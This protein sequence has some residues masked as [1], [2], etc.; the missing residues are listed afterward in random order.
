[1]PTI[2]DLA[3]APKAARARGESLRP[4]FE[5]PGLTRHR[6]AI[7]EHA[8]G[9]QI[10][11]QKDRYKVIVGLENANPPMGYEFVKGDVE[12]YDT[13]ADPAEEHN[14]RDQE[15][16]RVGDFLRYFEPFRAMRYDD[17]TPPDSTTDAATAQALI[18]LG[19]AGQ[20]KK[21]GKQPLEPPKPADATKPKDP[22]QDG[23]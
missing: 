3:R 16:K 6:A 9:W 17:L 15:P 2:L 22:K 19:Y 4:Y 21:K 11:A 7:F 5:N 18:Q 14:L 8:V 10:G 20:T 1:M 23:K 13:P 12:L